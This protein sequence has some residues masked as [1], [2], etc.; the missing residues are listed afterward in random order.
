MT[1]ANDKLRA[2]L[3]RRAQ[4]PILRITASGAFLGVDPADADRDAAA[5][6]LLGGEIPAGA[7]EGDTLDVFVYLDSEDRP[8]ATTAEP[9]IEL[10]DVAFLT[11]TD[12]A[13]FGAFVDWGMPKE[14]LVPH[15]EQTRDLRVGDRHPIGLFLDASGRLAGTMRVAEMLDGLGA[16][17]PSEWVLGEAWRHDPRIGTFIIVERTFVGLVPASEP[18]GLQRGDAARFRVTTV[19]PDGKI[20][21]SLRRPAEEEREDD[22]HALLAA[23]SRAGAPRVSDQS[24]PEQIRKLF[25]LSKKAFK[26]AAG[27]LLK[28]GSIR[29]DEDGCFVPQAPPAHSDASMPRTTASSRASKRARSK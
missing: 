12:I 26:R 18:H 3:G 10:G 25:G 29:A 23:L 20:V 24:S 27:R 8:I 22:A 15:A 6:L 13:P 9:K 4:L 19:H 5:I 2:L 28:E 7:K 1:T 21:L 11:V 14:L 16:F 17:T